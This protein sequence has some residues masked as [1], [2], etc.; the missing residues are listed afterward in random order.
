MEFEAWL[1]EHWP[2]LQRYAEGI[3]KDREGGAELMEAV[4]LRIA[5]GSLTIDIG[6]APLFYFYHALRNARGCL[7]MEFALIPADY[8]CNSEDMVWAKSQPLTEWVYTKLCQLTPKQREVV[9]YR[10][11]GLDWLEINRRLGYSVHSGSSRN[12]YR[13]AVTRLRELWAQAPPSNE[14]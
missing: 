6:K 7:K 13:A 5:E 4:L 9:E 3:A 12:L 11:Q 1:R 8:E 2:T 14:P 10:L